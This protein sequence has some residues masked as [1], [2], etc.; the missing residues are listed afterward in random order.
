MSFRSWEQRES[1][2]DNQNID[3]YYIISFRPWGRRE[4]KINKQNVD[5]VY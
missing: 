5:N 4:S 1:K 3:N 2:T